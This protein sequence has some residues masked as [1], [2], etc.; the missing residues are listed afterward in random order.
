MIPIIR[1]EYV[2]PGTVA[3]DPVRIIGFKRYSPGD[4]GPRVDTYS[5]MLPEPLR[6]DHR[7]VWRFENFD[8]VVASI[9]QWFGHL[10]ETEESV[11]GKLHP[12]YRDRVHFPVS[13]YGD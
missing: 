2:P 7:E 12:V 8:D 11:R 3:A 9:V 4:H 13:I 1:Y 6:P 5:V 10:G